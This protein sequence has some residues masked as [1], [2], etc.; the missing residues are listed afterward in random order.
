MPEHN[1]L[2]VGENHHPY[3]WIVADVPALEALSVVSADVYKVAYVQDS[4]VYTL[5]STSPAIWTCVVSKEQLELDNV[6]NTSDVNKPVSTA[7]AT[8]IST[9]KSEAIASANSY[10]DGLVTGLWDDR[11]NYDASGGAY[12]SSGGSGTA[13]A[14][15]KGDIW[16]IS[17][18]GTLPTGQ[19]VTAG[20]T[21]R[22]LID[23]PGNTQANWAIAENNVGYVPENSSNK[24][25]NVAL[26]TSDTL[27]PTQK[28]VKSYVDSAVPVPTRPLIAPGLFTDCIEDYTRC[29]FLFVNAGS[30]SLIGGSP[31]P[32][33]MT[34]AIGVYTIDT[35]ST[36]HWYFRS[37]LT[38]G[39]AY[40]LKLN[41]AALLGF[42]SFSTTDLGAA[43]PGT[44]LQYYCGF[45]KEFAIESGAGPV[46][47]N[48]AMLRIDGNQLI[49]RTYD[50]AD[51]TSSTTH[52][53]TANSRITLAVVASSTEVR[54]YCNGALLDTITTHIPTDALMF[55]AGCRATG[56]GSAPDVHID[57]IGLQYLDET[58]RTI[59]LPTA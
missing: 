33:G 52:A 57:C 56:S 49:C 7:Q 18:A 13:G 37:G 51:T 11:G 46:L 53:L 28:A 30:S 1:T 5:V 14:V 42:I 36:H 44:D 10:A 55:R 12:P 4:G 17:V 22:A 19:A 21:V 3:N 20:D 43:T 27:Y 15:K 6:D 35:S 54:F 39:Y 41:A 38:S 59:S 9:A 34:D 29:P 25:T 50:G 2:G 8:A 23:T 24:S 26:G 16:T 58:G 47:S 45:M 40:H 32:T 31:A 48:Q